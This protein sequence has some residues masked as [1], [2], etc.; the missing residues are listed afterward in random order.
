V[1]QVSFLA[2]L[3]AALLVWVPWR[4]VLWR[5]GDRN[6]DREKVVAVLFAW[7]LAVVA[8]TLFPIQIVLYDWDFHANLVPLVETVRM[9]RG[10]TLHTS[11]TN[12]GGNLAMFVPFGVLMPLLFAKSR[13]PLSLAAQAF[14]VTTLIEAVQWLSRSRIFDVDDLILNTAGGLLGLGLY[15]VGVRVFGRGERAQDWL[16]RIVDEDERSPLMRAALPVSLAVALALPF[17]VIPVMSETLA[18]GTGSGSI[19]AD[20][21]A[22]SGGGRVVAR[23]EWDTSVYVLTVTGAGQ[24]EVLSVHDYL[25]VLPGRYWHGA[26]SELRTGGE[27]CWGWNMTSVE[28]ETDVARVLVYGTNRRAKAVRLDVGTTGGVRSLALPA[29]D[30]FLT[31]LPYEY[32]ADASND[33]IV[34]FEPRFFDASGRDVTSALRTQ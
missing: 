14:A 17:A 21:I 31:S 24:D 19:T 20:A 32:R 22:S 25:E 26:D 33:G 3:G 1:I 29:V 5:K 11:I 13:R 30:F 10:A 18:A 28:N 6:R 7:A 16:A 27:D 4:V 34:S 9:W 2:A 8:L 23:E 12:V 15:H